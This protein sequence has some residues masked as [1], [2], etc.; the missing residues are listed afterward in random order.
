MGVTY[1]NTLAPQ[2]STL[3]QFLVK[4]LMPFVKIS[5]FITRLWGQNSHLNM[6]TEEDI[7]SLTRLSNHGG[8][9]LKQEAKWVSNALKLDDV[10]VEDIMTPKKV[11]CAFGEDT[12]LDKIDLDSDH[13]RFSRIPVYSKDNENEI[14]GI[15]RRQDIFQNLLRGKKDQRIHNLMIAPDFVSTNMLLHELLDRFL[16]TRR[17][18]FCVEDKREQYVGVVTLED[19]LEF[20]IGDEIVDELDLHEDMQELAKSKKSD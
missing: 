12:I 16:I 1:A 4:I 5:V 9:I 15:V 10:Y 8:E 20:L 3:I 18:L 19:V 14:V 7:I 2:L 6:P 11:V 13:W 17:H